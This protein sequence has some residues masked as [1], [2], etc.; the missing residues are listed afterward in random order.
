MNGLALHRVSFPLA[1][2][3]RPAVIPPTRPPPPPQRRVVAAVG[4]GWSAVPAGAAANSA[5][6]GGHLYPPEIE[7]FARD[8]RRLFQ[9]GERMA[10]YTVPKGTRY[11]YPGV[12]RPGV[13]K[14]REI[15][16]MVRRALD[17][18]VGDVPLKEKFRRLAHTKGKDARIV[19]A[20][21]D[22]S[23][24]LPPYR[25]GH[26]VRQA[27]LEAAEADAMEAGLTPEQITFVCSIALHRFI[28]PDEFRHICGPRLFGRYHPHGRMINFNAVDL[29]HSVLLGETPHQEPVRVCKEFAEAD[30]TVYANCNYVAMD[31]GFKSFSTGLVHYESLK[32]N[33]DCA[34]LKD[35]KSLYDPER[36]ALHKSFA[37]IGKVIKSQCDIFHVETVVDD[38]TFPWFLEWVT[39]PARLWSLLDKVLCFVNTLVLRFLPHGLR[40]WI[41]WSPLVRGPFG[42][43]HVSA[44]DTEAVHKATLE[45]NYR[46]KVVDVPSQCDVLVVGPSC[47]G[48][49]TKDYA[50]NPLLVN[51]YRRERGRQPALPA[52]TPPPLTPPSTSPSPS[53]LLPPQPRL[54]VQPVRRWCPLAQKG[55]RDRRRQ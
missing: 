45:L 27:I 55:R 24:P 31:G 7:T 22:V 32:V 18:P 1:P 44:G 8:E 49:Y 33:H 19:M 23:V 52:Y 42:L 38:A 40:T 41:F 16:A 14:R 20:F 9:T 2:P 36:S 30:L 47:I 3:N 21:D 43:L 39:K 29:E 34:T 46:D 6:E 13:T 54:L 12:R 51:T 37:R 53:P 15:A 25:A 11:I 26:D 28:R 17:H 48:P 4:P 10:T 35:T 5:L 50:M